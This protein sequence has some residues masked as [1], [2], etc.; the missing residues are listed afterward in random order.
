MQLIAGDLRKRTGSDVLD[1][2]SQE[3][4]ER[5]AAQMRQG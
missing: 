3:R 1:T 5:F 2:I 4:I